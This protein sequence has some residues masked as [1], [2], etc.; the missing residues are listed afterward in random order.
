MTQSI[1]QAN[2]ILDELMGMAPMPKSFV[3]VSSVQKEALRRLS[4]Q[5]KLI[6]L[7]QQ[8]REDKWV[9]IMSMVPAVVDQTLLFW[10]EENTSLA[11][12]NSDERAVQ[13]FQR[14][15]EIAK[16]IMEL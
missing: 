8:A 16:G 2:Q 5:S 15:K 7:L 13:G 14:M 4:P 11:L 3:D 6:N 12:A 9:E 1:K 10:I